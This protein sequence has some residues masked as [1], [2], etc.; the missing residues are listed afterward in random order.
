VGSLVKVLTSISA[1]SDSE[2]KLK[3]GQYLMKLRRTEQSVSVF[4]DHPVCLPVL[5]IYSDTCSDSHCCD[6]YYRHLIDVCLCTLHNIY[7]EVSVCMLIGVTFGQ[8]WWYQCSRLYKEDHG[9]VPNYLCDF[10]VSC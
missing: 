5:L 8:I 10:T 3:I 2:K 6:C 7:M 1:D 4:L 9:E